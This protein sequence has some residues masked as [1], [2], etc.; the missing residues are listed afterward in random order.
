MKDRRY[1]TCFDFPRILLPNLDRIEDT[2]KELIICWL[3]TGNLSVAL[4]SLAT[5]HGLQS[6]TQNLIKKRFQRCKSQPICTNPCTH[7]IHTAFISTSQNP[8]LP[9][10]ILSILNDITPPLSPQP[11]PPLQKIPPSTRPPPHPSPI[12]LPQ[13]TSPSKP[14]S[15][16]YSTLQTS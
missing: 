11:A 12:R 7:G 14:P 6:K 3:C 2:N 5:L 1:I 8:Y 15:P 9:P 16:S 4:L 13:A 10:D